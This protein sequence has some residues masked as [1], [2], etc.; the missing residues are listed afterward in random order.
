MKGFGID[1]QPVC[2]INFGQTNGKQ[3]NTQSHT[4][5]SNSREDVLNRQTKWQKI[6]WEFSFDGKNGAATD[7]N[8]SS[9][10]TRVE[11]KTGHPNNLLTISIP[12]QNYILTVTKRNTFESKFSK[13]F[14]SFAF[15]P[16]DRS[17]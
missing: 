9:L 5:K 7:E 8:V 11:T 4:H 2:A 1:V 12:L 3:T 13:L 16:S 17:E 6:T 15:L 14:Y 10:L